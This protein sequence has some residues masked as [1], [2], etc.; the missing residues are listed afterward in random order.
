MASV[1]SPSALETQQQIHVDRN[2]FTPIV[3]EESEMSCF[4]G[5]GHTDQTTVQEVSRLTQGCSPDYCLLMCLN[6]LKGFQ[7]FL[8]MQKVVG[9]AMEINHAPQNTVSLPGQVSSSSQDMLHYKMIK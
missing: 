6:I 3:V 2:R 9:G 1:C 4:H 7:G 8:L 5:D